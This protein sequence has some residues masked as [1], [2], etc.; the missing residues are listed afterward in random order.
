MSNLILSD[1]LRAADSRG[2]V[3]YVSLTPNGFVTT[4]NR[5]PKHNYI[6]VVD[7][8]AWLECAKPD[9]V[10]RTLIWQC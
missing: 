7:H 2:G 3:N 9:R 8:Q 5:P 4:R 6:R 1:V 10:E